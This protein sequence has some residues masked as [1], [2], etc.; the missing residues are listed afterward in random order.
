VDHPVC[1]SFRLPRSNRLPVISGIRPQICKY[2][3][4]CSSFSTRRSFYVSDL[5]WPSTYPIAGQTQ[6]CF[7]HMSAAISYRAFCHTESAQLRLEV[8][9]FADSVR[10]TVTDLLMQTR[11]ECNHNVLPLTLERLRDP[12]FIRGSLACCF[13]SVHTQTSTTMPSRP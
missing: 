3:Q 12:S 10:L 4:L 13:C 11:R 1:R 2:E 9:S 8:V 7:S 5:D 6:C